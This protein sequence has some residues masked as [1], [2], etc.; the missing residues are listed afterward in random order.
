METRSHYQKDIDY[1]AVIGHEYHQVVVD[2]RRYPNDLLF[3]PIAA[4]VPAGGAMLDLGT[5]TGHMLERFGAGRDRVVAV[6]HSEAMLTSARANAQRLGLE[7]SFHC[8]DLFEH[9]SGDNGLYRLVTCVGCLHHLLPADIPRLV[10]AAAARLEPGGVVVLAEPIEI[11]HEPPAALTAWNRRSAAAALG[12]SVQAEEPDEAPID[13]QLLESALAAAGL[14]IE[15]ESR[16]WEILPRHL[17]PT[18]MDRARIRWLH[19][20]H[21]ASG[22]V[23]A[24][25][26]RNVGQDLYG[27]EPA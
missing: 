26:A 20:R 6:D 13:R 2:P 16:S 11:D 10:A 3:A 7:V 15:Q 12:Y 14:A 8:A 5:G 23:L 25:L 9:L 4:R 19:W 21:G 1:H 17:P 22:N 24:L 18:L 27:Q